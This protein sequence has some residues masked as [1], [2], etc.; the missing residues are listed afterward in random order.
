VAVKILHQQYRDDSA[1]LAR[2]RREATTTGSLGSPNIVKI[3][4]IDQDEEL[5]FL[6]FELLEGQDLA[7]RISQR[8]LLPPVEVA[9]LVDQAARGLQVAH[10]AGVVHRDLKPENLFLAKEEDGREVIKILDFGISKT[11]GGNTTLTGEMSMLGT[12]DFMS[13]EQAMGMTNRVDH[14]A[15]VYALGAIAYNA[16]AGKRP[17]AAPSVP[18]L[19]WRICDEEPVPLAQRVPEVGEDVADVVAI[20]MA[21]RPHDRYESVEAFAGDLTA[22]INGTLSEEARQRAR[23]LHRGKAASGPTR[24]KAKEPT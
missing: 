24:K 8:G 9:Q 20:A 7:E 16:L 22:A 10:D 12:P 4:D 21:K 6:V 5:P 14:R 3:I 2:F 11:L 13:P 18:V 17:F 15:D 1:L 23:A 19:L